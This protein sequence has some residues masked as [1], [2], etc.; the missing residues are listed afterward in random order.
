M[1]RKQIKVQTTD[2]CASTIPYND[3]V[4]E[5]KAILAEIEAAERGQLRLGELAD[6][7]EPKYKDRTLAKL[8][9]E[10]GV[11]PCTLA[12]YRDV[13]RA[14]RDISA[15]GRES[16]SYAVLRELA[17]HPEREQLIS[18]HPNLTKR[19]ARNLMRGQETAT[20][21]KQKQTQ[22]RED[23]WLRDNRRWFKEVC[24]IANE[25]TDAANVAFNCTPEQLNN[26]LRAV[27]PAMLMYI[28]GGGRMLV[29][30]ARYLAGHFEEEDPVGPARP[31]EEAET[32]E[33][34]PANSEASVRRV[35]A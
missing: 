33:V 3:A 14:W 16:V 29:D 20:K 12:R 2:K 25:A 24:D 30:L 13:Y 9:A 17:T 6:K 10:L 4:R 8:A 35:A 26:L 7:V 11:A 1:P 15:P 23:D 19:G 18:K 21:D 5:G 34:E 32:S 28:Q 27:D 31:G 22:Q